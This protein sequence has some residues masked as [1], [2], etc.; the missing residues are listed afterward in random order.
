MAT[1][2]S[3]TPVKAD[4]WHQ[5]IASR[6]N[7]N[8]KLKLDDDVVVKGKSPGGFRGLDVAGSLYVGGLPSFVNRPS[9]LRNIGGFYGESNEEFREYMTKCC[10]YP[11]L[12]Y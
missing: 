7:F 2:R 6:E 10:S 12:K 3:R 8:G 4:R 1:L 11:G 5:V 9:A